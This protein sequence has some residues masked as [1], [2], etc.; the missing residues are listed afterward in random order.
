MSNL[1]VGAVAG[2]V[3]DHGYQAVQHP[4]EA[5]VALEAV[6]EGF[7][8]YLLVVYREGKV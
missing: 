3:L 4:T 1:A 8:M 5:L 7:E 6:G 2:V